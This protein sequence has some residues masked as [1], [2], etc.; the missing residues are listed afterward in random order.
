MRG[1]LWG[2]AA[3]TLVLVVLQVGLRDG[4]AAAA[5]AGS[6]ALVKGLRRLFSPDVAGVPQKGSAVTGSA[7]GKFVPKAG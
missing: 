7:H 6:N 1:G 4:T 2:F 5:T 3:G